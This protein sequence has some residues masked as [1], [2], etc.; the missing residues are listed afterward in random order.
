MTLAGGL[1]LGAH[2]ASTPRSVPIVMGEHK[3]FCEQ[4]RAQVPSQSLT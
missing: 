4:A 3:C 2:P 1:E